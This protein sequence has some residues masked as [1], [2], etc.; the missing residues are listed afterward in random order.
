MRKAGLK[1][2]LRFAY[3][4]N[5]TEP[6]A[7]LTVVLQHLDQ[8]KPCF[9]KNMDVIALM[10]AGFIGAWG[11]M[12]SSS[13]NLDKPETMAV[14]L[15]KMLEVLPDHR[16]IQV[17]TPRYKMAYVQRN[18]ALTPDESF[19]G[20]KVARVGHYNDCFL[21]SPTDYGT[22]KAIETE[23]E[24]IHAEGLFL[25]VGGETCPPSGIEPADCE[26]AENELRRLRWNYLNESYYRG[27]NDRWIEQGCMDNIIRELGY[28][29]VLHSA[30]Y[31]NNVSENGELKI[32]MNISN[33][34]YGCLYNPRRV[35]F[36][37]KNT[38]TPDIYFA[39]AKDDPRYWT[40]LSIIEIST[41]LGIPQDMPEG[42]YELYLNLP[43]PAPS[44]YDNPA[45]SIRLANMNVWDSTTGYNNLLHMVKVG[46]KIST[47][48]TC[49]AYFAK[50]M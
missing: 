47:N 44:I 10:Q 1:C 23:K 19:S 13:N 35:E 26:K 31:Q 11:E 15:D 33:I 4:G 42:D 43:D 25:P 14:I 46:S 48:H 5:Q 45:Y 17:R 7:P 32:T 18:A 9:E 21:A 12:H 16:M 50:K 38:V 37:L 27:V 41:S 8:L 6:D 36:I 29:F 39:I 30:E 24:Y 22:Y 2:I 3:S 40:P 34:G 28:R 20:S 49:D